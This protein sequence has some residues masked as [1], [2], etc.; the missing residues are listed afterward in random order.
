MACIQI[1]TEEDEH[2]KCYSWIGK[3]SSKFKWGWAHFKYNFIIVSP[4]GYPNSVD[5]LNVIWY[6]VDHHALG[7]MAIY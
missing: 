2:T 6:F 4:R 5:V 3:N 1:I 7:K